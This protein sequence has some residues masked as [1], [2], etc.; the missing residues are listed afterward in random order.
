MHA[1]LAGEEEKKELVSAN[2]F[3]NAVMQITL[4][5][6]AFSFD[7]VITAVALSPHIPVIVAA[8]VVSMIVMMMASGGTDQV[9]SRSPR[10]QNAGAQLHSD[11]RHHVGSSNGLHFHIPR[12]YIYFSFA[13]AIGVEIL[14]TLAVSAADAYRLIKT[15]LQ[16][17]NALEM[18]WKDGLCKPERFSAWE[19]SPCT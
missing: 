5:D 14:N 2:G 7:S 3:M 10:V 17:C 13:F 6:L 19:H 8:I 18:L 16:K 12:G 15:R 9:P 4:I 11:D 1:D